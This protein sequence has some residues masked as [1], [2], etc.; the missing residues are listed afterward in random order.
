LSIDP[1]VTDANTGSSFNRYAYA[2]N[3]PFKYIDPDGRAAQVA[4][5]FFASLPVLV[6]GHYVLPGRQG[7]EDSIRAIFNSGNGGKGS[8]T[9]KPPAN[10]Q[11]ITNPPQ[12]PTIPPD[13]ES[14]PGRNGGTVY[15]PPGT[16]PADG[17]HIRVMPPG[18]TPTPGYEDGYWRWVNGNKQPMDPSTGKPGKGQG[19]THVPLPPDWVPPE[20]KP[21]PEPA[22]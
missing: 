1:V 4:G 21:P 11:P 18:S 5:A 14:R 2:N 13:W 8:G 3:S 22:K 15:Y 19:D 20:A 10:I 7:R 6:V 16:E 12:A 17:E 9:P